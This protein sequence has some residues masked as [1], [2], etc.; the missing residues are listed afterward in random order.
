MENNKQKITVLIPAYNSEDIIGR[1][2]ESALWVDEVF[3][4]DSFS[5]DKTVEIAKR[6]GARVVQHEYVYSAKQKNWAIPQAKN[7]W[8]M[9]L[10]TDEVITKELKKEIKDLFKSGEIEKY[11][12]FGIARPHYFLGKWLRWGGRYPLHNIRLF[13]RECRYE[14]RDVHAH[15]ILDKDRIKKL[16]GDM[17]HYSDPD[18]D[19]FFEKFN[20]YTTYQANYM[21]K[22]VEGEKDF[23]FDFKKVFSRFIYMKSFVKDFW[24]FLPFAPVMRFVYMYFIRLGLLDGRHGFM[25]AVL[26]GFQDYVSKTKF[27]ELANKNP[28][29]RYSAQKFFMNRVVL[30]SSLG[31]KN[32]P[33]SGKKF[34]E[35]ALTL[36]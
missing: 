36:L 6:M 12:G 28:K 23:E 8:V 5:T 25:I 19:N 21:M 33:K 1:C 14:D 24:Y 9:V 4:V 7:N 16:K 20:R 34:F 30:S 13:R 22:F 29:F 35:K 26:Y 27:M 17:L 11:D 31:K 15:I 18:L 10:D 3:V 32:S 2:I